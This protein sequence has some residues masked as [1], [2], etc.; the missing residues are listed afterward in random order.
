MELTRRTLLGGA[1]SLGALGIGSVPVLARA[2]DGDREVAALAEARLWP[3]EGG[4]QDDLRVAHA[5]NPE[6]DLMSRTFL[7]L[8]L[9]DLAV[10]DPGGWQE[11]AVGALDQMIADTEEHVQ[12]YGQEYFL[13]SY[14]AA[15]TC[16]GDG[17]SLFTDGERLMMMVIRRLLSDD[18][19]ELAR[20]SRALR[21]SVRA[22]MAASPMLSAESYPNECWTFCN[23]LALAAQRMMDRLEGTDDGAFRARWAALARE[24]L[25]DPRTGMLVSSFTW[26]GTHGDGPEGSTIWLVAH[27]LRLIDADL[28]E[29]QYVLAREA[30]GRTVLGLGYAREWPPGVSGA[31]DVDSGIVL[32]V[33]QASPSSS[34]L[35]ILASRSF[36]DLRWHRAL[37]ASLQVTALPVEEQGRRRFR[38][39]NAVGDAVILAGM[40]AGPLWERVLG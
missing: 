13:M 37:R 16:R 5:M 29:E 1:L 2:V 30:L 11:R 8:A 10:L 21:D 22:S 23:T 32:P 27:M 18:D 34:G 4:P 19:P 24:R 15:E 40:V 7:A 17:R 12:R 20:R 25:I 26:S 38:A 28:A 6:Y 36:G 9:G 35:A 39:S 3:W 33:L 14:W 31:M